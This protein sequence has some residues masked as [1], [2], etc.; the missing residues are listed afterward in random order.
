MVNSQPSQPEL[1]SLGS[2]SSGNALVIKGRNQTVLIDCGLSPRQLAVRLAE[3]HLRIDDID[4]LFLTHEHVDHVKS[5]PEFRRRPTEV[6]TSRGT[7]GALGLGR[8]HYREAV[9]LNP[10]MLGSIR[11]TPIPVM[12]D[13]AE[14][15]AVSV[16]IDGLIVTVATDLGAVSE[17][18]ID[19]LAGSDCAI[20]ESNHDLE[21]LKWGPYPAHLKR[22]VMGDRG[23]LSNDA[24]GLAL[25]RACQKAS[26][27][28]QVWLAHLSTTNNLPKTASTTVAAYVAHLRPQPL[29]RTV[30]TRLDLPPI[31][32]DP[33]PLVIETYRQ[34]SLW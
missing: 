19:A 17:S 1:I 7:A 12:H 9:G 2:G 24:C 11:L 25:A 14:P 34:E 6:V 13:G 30:L 23:H 22:R 33:R 4:L 31:G 20:L 28:Q 15:M 26:R 27:L 5:L 21:M 10:M 32:D 3:I 29:A 18:F 8:G 16:E